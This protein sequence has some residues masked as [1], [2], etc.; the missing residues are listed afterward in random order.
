MKYDITLFTILLIYFGDVFAQQPL[1]FYLY[2]DK[3]SNSLCSFPLSENEA[4]RVGN[5]YLFISKIRTR[6]IDTL[7]TDSLFL[8]F[9]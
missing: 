8:S 9:N 7:I 5:N 2:T 1:D 3:V 6:P 4:Q